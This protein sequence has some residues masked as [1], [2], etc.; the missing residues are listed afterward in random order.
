MSVWLGRSVGRSVFWSV[1]RSCGRSVFRSVGRY[2]LKGRSGRTLRYGYGRSGR[3]CGQGR[4]FGGQGQDLV[5]PRGRSHRDNGDQ[6]TGARGQGT[7]GQGPGAR[8]PGATGDTETRV[9]GTERQEHREPGTHLA[10]A[11]SQGQDTGPGAQ[12]GPGGPKGAHGGNQENP[13]GNGDPKGN[14]GETNGESR[15]E[16]KG[17]QRDNTG[18]HRRNRRHREIRGQPLYRVEPPQEKGHPRGTK[19]TATGGPQKLSWGF[20]TSMGAPNEKK[21]REKLWGTTP[22]KGPVV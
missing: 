4:A 22:C 20:K 7:R 12:G 2:G 5:G 3:T 8:R 18:S 16:T 11:K 19:L 10:G 13:Q 14:T 15:G 17:H 1:G 6:G 21:P 9:Q